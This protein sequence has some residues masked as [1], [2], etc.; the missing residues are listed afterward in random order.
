MSEHNQ[1]NVIE[2]LEDALKKEKLKNAELNKK[3]EKTIKALFA[4]SNAVNTTESLDE[5]YKSI[6][7]CL[8]ETIDV[9]NFFIALYDKKKDTLSFPYVVDIKDGV[10]SAVKGVSKSGSLTCEVI[11]K[12]KPLFYKKKEMLDRA[13]KMNLDLTGTPSELWLGVPLIVKEEVIGAIVIQS[14]NN[15][16]IYDQKDMDLLISIS[17]QIGLAI[18]RRLAE[19][20]Q[21]K[22]EQIKE[23]LF[24]ISNA[25]NTTE[26]LEELYQSI[27]DALNSKLRLPNF[28][29]CLVDEKNKII[30]FPFY[31]D[32]HDPHFTGRVVNYDENSKFIT[33]EVVSQ[34]KPVFLNK[35]DLKQRQIDDK[36]SGTISVVWIGVPLLIRGNVIGVIAAQHYSDPDYFSSDDIKLFITASEQIAL[37][38]DRKRSQE[39]IL[40]QKETLEKK[41]EEIETLQG[42]IP[43]CASCK[44]IRDDQGYWNILESYI[45]KHSDASFSHSM[46]PECSDRLYGEESWYIDM[47]KKKKTE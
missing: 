24:S 15:P 36:I 47:K 44:K 10:L 16:D 18:D 21:E 27:Y 30:Q 32:E 6:H 19:D 7:I 38:I 4:I 5:L 8:N 33:L 41:I 2:S 3:S 39:I 23:V 43:I 28:Y 26:N 29:I 25:V 31:L 35:T 37:A 14:Y 13:R 34:K 9:S 45:Q 1:F 42:I 22:S 17:D 40:E 20:A 46:C 11:Q 12:G